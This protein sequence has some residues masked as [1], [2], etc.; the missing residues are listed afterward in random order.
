MEMTKHT[1]VPAADLEAGPGAAK[2]EVDVTA[3]TLSSSGI[4]DLIREHPVMLF[5][6]ATCAFC[7]ELK[8]TLLTLGIPYATFEVDKC[9][10]YAEITGKL[11]ELSGVSTY[12]NLFVKGKSIG[13]CMDCK[14]MEQKGTFLSAFNEVERIAPA[15]EERLTRTTLFWFPET[16]NRKSAQMSGLLSFIVCVLCVAF[17]ESR[18]TKW[19]VLGLALDFFGRLIGGGTWTPIG[20]ASTI[21]TSYWEP[22]FMCGAPKQFAAFCGLFMSALSAALLLSGQRLGGTVVIGMLIGPTGLEGFLDFC[23]G[24]WMFG[25]GITFGV[26][27][28]SVYRPYLNLYTAKEWAYAFSHQDRNYPEAERV[29]VLPAGQTTESATDLIRKDR[30]ETEYKL[31]DSHLIKHARVDLF[32]W[33]M[34]LAALC[35]VFKLA[36]DS[37]VHNSQQLGEWGTRRTSNAIG[38]ASAVLF[39]FFGILYIARTFLYTNKVVKEWRH[40]V[41][42]NLFS[43]I[44]ICLALYGYILYNNDLNFGI[45]LVWIASGFQMFIAVEKVASLVFH[46]VSDEL[47]NPS[48]MMSPV[49]NFVCVLGLAGYGQEKFRRTYEDDMNYLHIARVWFAV[50]ALYS[51]VLFTVTFNKA[52]RDHHSENRFRPTLFIWMATFSVAGPAY[53]AVSGDTG[54]VYQSMWYLAL[55]F[56]AVNILGYLKGFYTYVQDMSIFIYAFSYTALALSTFHYYVAVGGD[57]FT[58]ICAIISVVLACT[59]VCVCSF[60]AVIMA[61]DGALFRP[62]PKWGPVNFM[63]L[64]HEAFRL[65]LPKLVAWLDTVGPDTTPSAMA[66]FVSEFEA[67]ITTY[68]EHGNHE[69]SVLFPAVC[70]YF[71][72][73]ANEAHEE[74]EQQHA[75]VNKMMDAVGKWR[76]NSDVSSSGTLIDLLKSEFPAWSTSVLDHLRHEEAKIS[77]VAR[78]YFTLEIQKEL[79]NRVFSL[80]PTEKWDVIMPFV[81]KNLGTPMWKSQFVKTFIWA[82]PSRAQEIGL[83]LYR[84]LDSCTYVFLA[85]EIPEMI[86]RGDSGHRRAF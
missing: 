54:L 30:F 75:V 48:I 84:S 81:I 28:K 52:I 37:Y 25:W 74:H 43:A 19:V 31:Q 56:F 15:P 47:L 7:L 41:S 36:D 77:V 29:H 20:M 68:L 23:A 33:P 1:A 78:K 72:G 42:G 27:P 59:S 66:A 58:R 76:Q 5:S 4:E 79:T 70:R 83:M 17:Y 6:K 80:T 62:K 13:G 50:A 86:P 73:F 61:I 65:G 46:P 35:F 14:R 2:G 82:N 16:V 10:N 22:R 26:V 21:L 8:S 45:T 49:A 39:C 64:T 40:P 69:E 67:M 63:K 34:A 44:N 3:A 71:P 11:N 32:G 55:F 9:Q 51:I 53:F 12:P 85:E 24:C 18:A 60:Q 57:Q 38:I